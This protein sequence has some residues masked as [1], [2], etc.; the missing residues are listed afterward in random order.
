MHNNAFRP[1]Q[2]LLHSYRATENKRYASFNS[3]FTPIN[4]V[5]AFD[6]SI[7]VQ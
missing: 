7:M 1:A 5:V 6:Y 2:K 3:G 4:P